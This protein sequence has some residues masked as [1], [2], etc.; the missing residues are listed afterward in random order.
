MCVCESMRMYMHVCASVYVNVSTVC[1]YVNV[2]VY[3]CTRV[4]IWGC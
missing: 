2:F 3:N 1:V 4:A